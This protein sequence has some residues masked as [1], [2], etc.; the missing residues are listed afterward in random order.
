LPVTHRFIVLGPESDVAFD[1]LRRFGA[2]AR[3]I[4]FFIFDGL[5]LSRI[6]RQHVIEAQVAARALLEMGR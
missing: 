3:D 2:I 4:E 5:L 6:D 1:W